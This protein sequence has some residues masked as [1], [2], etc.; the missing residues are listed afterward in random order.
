MRS[1]LITALLIALAAVCNAV[2][3]T[4]DHHYV[5]SIFVGWGDWWRGVVDY[6]KVDWY[7]LKPFVHDAWHCFKNLMVLLFLIAIVKWH[8]SLFSILYCHKIINLKKIN[9]YIYGTVELLIYWGLWSG[10]HKLFYQIILIN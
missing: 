3:D 2:I 6:S 7:L 4:I 1:F 9:R 5:R 8:Q 10:I